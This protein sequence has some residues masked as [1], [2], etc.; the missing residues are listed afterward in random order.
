MEEIESAILDFINER[1]DY[2]E[3]TLDCEVDVS[4]TLEDPVDYKDLITH[5]EDFI[6]IEISPKDSQAMYEGTFR[7][8]VDRIVEILA[9]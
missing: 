5:L 1:V 6:D 3:E 4:D 7:E 8:M 9:A 2:E